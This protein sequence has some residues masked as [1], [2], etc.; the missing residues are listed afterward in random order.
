[1]SSRRT[2]ASVFRT[3]SRRAKSLLAIVGNVDGQ[4]A[5]DVLGLAPNLADCFTK[6]IRRYAELLAP[7]PN[8]VV[9]RQADALAILA[10]VLG[11]VVSHFALPCRGWIGLWL[12]RP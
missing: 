3:I 10:A 2:P 5:L 9:V 4:L 7:I 11:L 6:A 1:M 8:L 12:L